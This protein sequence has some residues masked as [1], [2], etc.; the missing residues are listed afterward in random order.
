MKQEL[1]FS[2]T[3]EE[4]QDSVQFNFFQFIWLVNG[5]V[6]FTS[7]IVHKSNVSNGYLYESNGIHHLGIEV[8]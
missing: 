8:Y 4:I 5:N 2:C 6:S 3:S 1:F 7:E